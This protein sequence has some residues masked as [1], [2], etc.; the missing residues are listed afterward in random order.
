MTVARVVVR[1]A[2]PGDAAAIALVHVA[3]WRAAYAGIVPATVLDNLSVERRE[4][5]WQETTANPGDVA[6]W[7]AVL[8]GN[9][10]GFA[11]GGP[12]RDDDLPIDV[13]ELWSIYVDP[14]AWGR[15]AGSALFDHAVAGLVHRG[16]ASLVLWVLTANERG[17]R[18]Y[19]HRGWRPD[20]AA[21]MLDFDGTPV[22]EMRYRLRQAA[23]QRGDRTIG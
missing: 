13:G 16:F 7:V 3:S 11:S 14:G 2:T 19:D 18:F 10:V 21:R 22:E 8:D 5:S 12:H 4:A 9:V 15:R 6:T 17:R 20:G 1:P 23:R